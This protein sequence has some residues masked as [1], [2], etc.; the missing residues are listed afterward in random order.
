MCMA[1]RNVFL[2]S[3]AC[4]IVRMATLRSVLRKKSPAVGI[5]KLKIVSGPFRHQLGDREISE[6]QMP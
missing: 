5:G 2:P 3:G 1:K 4:I 6:P